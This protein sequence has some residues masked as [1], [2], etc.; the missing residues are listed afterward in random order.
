M[1]EPERVENKSNVGIRG[2][3]INKLTQNDLIR[4]STKS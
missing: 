1:Y 4:E 2:Q 3:L